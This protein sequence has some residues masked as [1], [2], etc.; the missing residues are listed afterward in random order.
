MFGD[1]VKTKQ[2]EIVFGGHPHVGIAYLIAV[3][4]QNNIEAKVFDT[5]VENDDR[6]LLQ[7][8]KDYQPNLIGITGFSYSY[9]YVKAIIDLV[10][11]QADCPVV[12][13]GPHVS[14]TKKLCFKDNRASLAIKGEG[15]VTFLELIREL[16]K[17]VSDF[18]KVDGLIWRQ[19]G[20]IIENRDRPFLRDLDSLPIP[21]YEAFKLDRYLYTKQHK[22]PIITSRG[23]PYGCNYCSVRL[24][25]GRNFRPRSPENVVGEIEHWYKRGWCNFE[26]NDDCF[27]VDMDR[28]K[29][30][31]DLIIGKKLKI[32]YELYNGI[33]VDRI[34]EELL[35]KMKAS[36]CIF[37]SYGCE[38]GSQKILDRIGKKIKLPQVRQAVQ[39]TNKVGI[40]NS[41]NFIIGHPGETIETAMES[42]RFADSLPTNF[43]NFYNLVPYPGTELFE[44]VDKNARFLV[45]K[46]TYLE[47]ISYRD[48]KP[49]FE[50]PEFSRRERMKVIKK[51]FNLYEKKILE[52]RLG[53]AG[54]RIMYGLTRLGP[55]GKWAR[56]FALESKFGNK[57]YQM[58]SA[59][60]RASD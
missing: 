49:V 59:N 8:M 23:C 51:G 58:L 9:G 57:I 46:K 20:E 18:S 14:A 22:M 7:L 3:L 34:D 44:W 24:S 38:S 5:L 26:F 53:K 12:L 11:D 47:S 30:I 16:Q 43:V 52:F 28:A 56:Q 60:S 17:P 37:I 54:G 25:M 50:T 31:C 2:G 45:P 32:K 48:N 35:R 29:K 36:G 41:V 1:E 33:R 6:K 27:N 21:A 55:I 39:L 15:E 40:K 10:T 42:I 13:G 4:R 19:D